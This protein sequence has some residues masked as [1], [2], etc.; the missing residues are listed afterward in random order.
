MVRFS[1]CLKSARIGIVANKKTIYLMDFKGFGA[2]AYRG[3]SVFAGHRL[4]LPVTCPIIGVLMMG[5]YR[6]ERAIPKNKIFGWF[7]A[8][9]ACPAR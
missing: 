4:G 9:E 8:H 5:F 6:S 3:N 2:L 7:D 1:L